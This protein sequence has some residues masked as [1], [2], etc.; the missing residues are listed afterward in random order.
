MALLRN[1]ARC[2]RYGEVIESR[3]R[4][5]FVFCSCNAIFVDGGLDYARRGGSHE[6]IEDLSE[7]TDE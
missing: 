1:R 4:H 5:D 2:R 3:H 7:Y 6:D